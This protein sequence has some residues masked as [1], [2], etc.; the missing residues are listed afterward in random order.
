M[1]GYDAEPVESE[2]ATNSMKVEKILTSI[3]FQQ[4]LLPERTGEL[5]GET[6]EEPANSTFKDLK[7]WN[8]THNLLDVRQKIPEGE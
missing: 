3:H 5:I 2:F 4:L 6:Q 1:G 8:R 7:A